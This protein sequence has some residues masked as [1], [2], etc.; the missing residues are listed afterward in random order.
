MASLQQ[1]RVRYG[2]AAVNLGE[3]AEDRFIV[4]E[5]PPGE[6]IRDYL[7]QRLA[8][9][10][11]HPDI[12]QQSV[13]RDNLIRLVALNLGVTLTSEATISG[14]LPGISF[15]PLIE[16]SLPFCAVWSADNDN[17]ALHRLLD[18]ARSIN[19]EWRLPNY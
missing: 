7:V 17:P 16:Q 2:R 19:G 14:Q 11:H 4:S 3:L 6:E 10:G 5:A 9:L 13:G 15:V 1:R 8:H 18:I 12:Q